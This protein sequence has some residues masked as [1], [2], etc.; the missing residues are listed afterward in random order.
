MNELKEKLIEME[1][2]RDELTRELQVLEVV[3]KQG[4][5]HLAKIKDQIAQMKI[6]IRLEAQ[7]SA[8]DV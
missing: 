8:E 3:Q 6:R 2:L 4:E 7:R 5:I 1:T